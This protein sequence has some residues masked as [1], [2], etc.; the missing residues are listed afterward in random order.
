[1]QITTKKDSVTLKQSFSFEDTIQFINCDLAD[2]DHYAL[3]ELALRRA[4]F[5]RNSDTSYSLPTIK[6]LIS[7][8]GVKFSRNILNAE[9]NFDVSFAASDMQKYIDRV[10]HE[11]TTSVDIYASV[12]GMIARRATELNDRLTAAEQAIDR[13]TDTLADNCSDVD[14]HF[15]H[16]SHI[17]G[18]HSIAISLQNTAIS[19][20]TR[21]LNKPRWW[22]FGRKAAQRVQDRAETYKV[23]VEMVEADEAA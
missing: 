1:M 14:R 19:F 13:M 8:V 18:Q 10:K 4:G 15:Q 20:I 5:A 7:G 6:A 9:S 23:N 3:A 11:Y 21:R 17:T 12:V 16:F 2:A 22:Q